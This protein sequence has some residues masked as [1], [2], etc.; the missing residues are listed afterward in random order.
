MLGID[1]AVGLAVVSF[2]AVGISIIRAARK[3][4]QAS[5]PDAQAK[6]ARNQGAEN[7][8]RMEIKEKMRCVSCEE[9]VDPKTDLFVNGRTWWHESCYRK[10]VIGDLK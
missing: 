1:I 2:V 5:D 6:S 10:H 4:Q 7:L 9:F 8:H 3:K